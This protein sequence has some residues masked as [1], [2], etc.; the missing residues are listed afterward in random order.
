MGKPYKRRSKN[1]EIN[2]W[3]KCIQ[4]QVKCKEVVERVKICKQ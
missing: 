1:Y 2:N 4:D 3:I